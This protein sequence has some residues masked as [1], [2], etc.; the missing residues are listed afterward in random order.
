MPPLPRP[1]RW[2]RAS[3]VAALLVCRALAT[4]SPPQ[5][6]DL[7]A[8]DAATA[9][10]LAA[11][12]AG[13]EIMFP[14][15]I[16]QGVRVA[17]VRGDFTVEEAV[18]R[19]LAG[20][21]LQLVRDAGSSALAVGRATPAPAA[22]TLPAAT[23]T[24]AST[25]S[26]AD[27]IVLTPFEVSTDK[28]HGYAATET[29]AGTR[30]RTNL[31]DV[32]AS[33]TILT[34]EFMQDLAVNSFDKA[35]LFTPSV[36]AVEGDNTPSNDGNATGQFLRGGTGQAYSIRG[37]TNTGNNGL[38]TLSHDFFNS[39]ETSD[40]YN[41]ERL[42]LARGPNALLIGVGEPQGAAI[43]TTKRAQLQHRKTQVQAQYDRWTSN[44]VALDHNQP[45]VKDR[46]AF[47]LNLLHAEK[48]EFRRFEGVNQ[49]RLTLG[50]TARPLA[51][52]K[53]TVNHENYSNHRNIV[54]LAWAFDSG[55]IQWLANGRP[56]VDF[57]P[58]GIA[59]ATANR[60]FVDANGNRLR[61]A[62]GVASADG[63]VRSVAD[64]NP[65]NAIT[66]NAAQQQVY[67]TGLKLANPVVNMR[68]QGVMQTD[69]FGG[70]STQSVQTVDPFQLYGLS[71][72]ANLNGGTWDQ[73]EQR[74]HGRWTTAFIEQKI[75]E[76]LYLEL[77]G[78][79]GRHH[80]TY[81]PDAFNVIKL[82]VNRYLPDGSVN[83]GYLVPYGDT[84]GQ[85]RDEI[86][87]SDEYRATL[88]YEVDLGKI[89]RWLGRQNFAAL[90]QQTR[91]KS[92][93]NIMRYYN[94][95]TIGLAGTG[96][97]GDATA[98]ASTLRGRAYYVNGQVPALPDQHFFSANLAQ[99]NA[100]GRMVGGSANDAAPINFALRQHLNAVKSGFA[101]EALSFGWQSWW[102]QNRLVTVAGYR[103]DGTKSYV[104]ETLRG[105]IDPAIP[106]SATDPLK[107]YF[108]SS[109]AVPLKATP[110][111][112]TA[113]ISRTFGAVFHALPWLSLNYS[114]STNFNPVADASWKNYQS[115][116]APNTTGRTEDYGV[117]FSL[118]DGRLSVGFNRFV[119]AANDQARLANQ[120]RAPLNSILNRLRTNYRDFGDSHF[121][122][123][124][125]PAFPI[126]NLVDNVSDTWSYRATG[127]ELNITFN[128]SR[129]WRV[130]LTGSENSN[131]LGTHLTSLGRYLNS[132]APF[133]GLVTWRKFAS[134][135]RKVEAGQ[136][137][138]SF[139]L[140]PADPAARS[141]AGADALLIEQQTATAER[142]YQ[143]ELAIEG[144]TTSRNGRYA[145]NGLITHVF[146]KEGRLK[147]WSVGGNFRWRS[148]S[149]IGYLRTPNAAGI[150]NGVIDPARPLKGAD[151]G[152]LGA[153]LSH[154]RR[155]FRNVTLRTQ[156][157]VEN[158]LDWSKPRLVSSDYDTNG[159]LGAANAIVPLRWELRR[160]RNFILTATFGF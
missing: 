34:P 71:R 68:F 11:Q 84:L 149:T 77:A 48:R 15:A 73:P 28:D 14:A 51:H 29:L 67:I 91:N 110:S 128:P 132:A 72:D 155:I 107:R 118:L 129:N 111:V 76:G 141:K 116:S 150:P 55:V 85:L 101:H 37:F 17:A 43:T 12:Q 130:A 94:L 1:S 115:E 58:Q 137:S 31:R 81:A 89:H 26:S 104:P 120:Y 109:V 119:A 78:N 158:P 126:V 160:P 19:M 80:R 64:F 50:V 144:I 114:R 99:I 75:L 83:P 2:L 112:D 90:G 147:G 56:T 136:R 47:R 30:M 123:M 79:A 22:R 96:W 18:T 97:S 134:E 131:V 10:R 9:L 21:A 42:T 103:R 98:A 146:P 61:V 121:I 82:D 44:R 122:Q 156:L 152:E 69:T 3:A 7:P 13:R 5:H 108:T 74:D 24:G 145:F 106:G 113:G 60:A 135:L 36:D 20:T 88:S 142:S 157:N 38:Q 62:P 117:R 87:Q 41:L 93:T 25:P 148:A 127:Y 125:T 65:R 33:L 86:A 46:L 154:E 59:W 151:N 52:T 95:A 35:L 4:P 105:F 49:D 140:N 70:A 32:G 57:V 53:I 143:D 63:F 100:L 92:D 39:F 27:T 102:L 40:N 133:E 23:A 45:L 124:D 159:V 138:A 153:M 8:G 54:P 6:F 16:V 66:Q 139:D